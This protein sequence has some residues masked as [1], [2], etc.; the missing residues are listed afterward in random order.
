MYTSVHS[1]ASRVM[2]RPQIFFPEQRVGARSSAT[3]VQS[4]QPISPETS[5]EA[6][7]KNL[8]G[9]TFQRSAQSTPSKPVGA[10]ARP[11]VSEQ[12]TPDDL[13]TSAFA[14]LG[15]SVGMVFGIQ[16]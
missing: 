10:K 9:D 13:P 11:Q 12:S 16:F 1:N 3:A 2:S 5:A 6:Q 7:V 14:K 8:H 4:I 15:S